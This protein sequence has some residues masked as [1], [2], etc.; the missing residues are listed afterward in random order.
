MSERPAKASPPTRKDKKQR[1][2]R[3]LPLPMQMFF[4]F[5]D[6][7]GLS[8][9]PLAHQEASAH[10]N[11]PLYMSFKTPGSITIERNPR[12]PGPKN[13][14]KRCISRQ[15][16]A[17]K[18]VKNAS[19]NTIFA[20]G[21]VQKASGPENIDFFVNFWGPGDHKNRQ[22]SRLR[23]SQKSLIFATPCQERFFMILDPQSM[24]RIRKN[25]LKI[26]PGSAKSHIW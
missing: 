11:I 17:P 21:E 20:P 14:L 3:R 23:G 15:K 13:R 26:D 6:F 1:N 22:K 10:E 25:Q 4:S 24:S 12:V 19:R 7:R 9:A 2:Y 5:V 18:I 8:G 16:Q